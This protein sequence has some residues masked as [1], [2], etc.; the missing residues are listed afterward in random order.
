MPS[1]NI[2][3]PDQGFVLNFT[4]F[5]LRALGRLADSGEPMVA[6]LNVAIRLTMWKHAALQASNLS[7]LSL[8]LGDVSSAVRQGE[9]SVELADRSGDAFHR[10][11]A[12]D[13]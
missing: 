2:S 8:T 10:M 12:I 3:E 1:T 5:A 13:Q 11:S 9:Q 4:T 6:A 7:E